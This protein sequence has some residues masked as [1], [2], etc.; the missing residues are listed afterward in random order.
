MHFT[1]QDQTDELSVGWVWKRSPSTELWGMPMSRKGGGIIKKKRS[2]YNQWGRRKIRI[3]C[4][5]KNQAKQCSKKDNELC[6]VLWIGQIRWG[7]T[8]FRWDITAALIRAVQMSD[9]KTRLI[10]AWQEII[11]MYL[12]PWGMLYCYYYFTVEI[13]EAD[14]GLNSAGTG[15][16]TVWLQLACPSRRYVLWTWTLSDSPPVV[17]RRPWHLRTTTAS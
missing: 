2:R 15:S 4:Y 13:T 1:S 11:F 5:S 9:E 10:R 14:G 17:E 6:Q 3:H 16:Q 12:I 8:N 7:L